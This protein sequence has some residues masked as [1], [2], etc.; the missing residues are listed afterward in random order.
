M[1]R[2]HQCWQ[3]CKGFPTGINVKTRASLHLLSLLERVVQKPTWS[4]WLSMGWRRTSSHL[5]SMRIF[6]GIDGQQ[7]SPTARIFCIGWITRAWPSMV[8]FPD[9]G[10]NIFD[11]LR[12]SSPRWNLEP[13]NFFEPMQALF[14]TLLRKYHIQNTI[15][16]GMRMGTL[17]HCLY[18]GRVVLLRGTTLMWWSDA[19]TFG[20]D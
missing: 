15:E 20:T 4:N 3:L 19:L 16:Q 1:E 7:M 14:V 12:L 10:S 5:I 17:F 8:H 18:V 6:T 13:T 9:R 11:A 2:S